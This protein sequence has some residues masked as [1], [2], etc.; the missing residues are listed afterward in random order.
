VKYIKRINENLLDDLGIE[1]VE[2][3]GEI[4]VNRDISLKN[5]DLTEI[6][7]K[8]QS[9]NGTIDVSNNQ[10]MSFEFLPYGAKE[11]II[12]NNPGVTGKLEEIINICTSANDRGY[13]NPKDYS[14]KHVYASIYNQFMEACV[15]NDVWYGGETN[16]EMVDEIWK[17]TKYDYFVK[18]RSTMISDLSDVLEIGDVKILSE[19]FEIGR[20]G[21]LNSDDF[22]NSIINKLE[23][24]DNNERM[25]TFNIISALADKGSD[26]EEY[27]KERGLDKAYRS[28]RN[29]SSLRDGDSE[30]LI[31]KI[32]QLISNKMNRSEEQIEHEENTEFFAFNGKFV[33]GENDEGSYNRKLEIEALVKVDGY[34]IEDSQTVGMMK[35]R[36]RAQGDIDT[37]II[38]I[39]KG[40]MDSFGEEGTDVW[41]TDDL[42]EYLLNAFESRM[43]K[44]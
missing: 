36:A 7:I 27:F 16:M 21:M 20:S 17:D 3:G 11:Y 13:E 5:K 6:D 29:A 38:S 34:N 22:M 23:S 8:F 28:L 1:Y 18:N 14:V 19:Y 43:R 33:F 44:I 39:E 41:Y 2:R 40:I 10:L 32:L 12:N 37:Y 42:P 15:E 30:R 26:F 25:I 4:V 9:V 31:S 35:M 24:E